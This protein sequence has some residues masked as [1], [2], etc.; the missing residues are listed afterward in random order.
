M[1]TRIVI[2]GIG[3]STSLGEGVSANW[4]ALTQGQRSFVHNSSSNGFL[5]AKQLAESAT[6]EALSKSNL[7]NFQGQ[8]PEVLLNRVWGLSLEVDP[9]RLGSTVS[10]SKPLFDGDSPQPPELLNE[11][12]RERFGFSGEARNVIAACATG[13]YSV[14]MAASWIEQGVC[15]VAL[16]GSVEPSPHPLIQAG[17]H[18]M[19]VTSIDGQTRPFDRH[20]SGFTFG[21]GAGILVLETEARARARGVTPY[22][23]LSGRALGADGHSAFTFNSQG[24]KIS[25]VIDQSLRSANLDARDILHVNAH[26]TATRHNDWI[27]TQALLKSFGD[28]AANLMISATKAST[29]H[30]LGASGAV[31]L[32]F[33]VLALRHQFVP[34]TATLET[35][36]PE[37]PLDYTPRVGHAATFDHAVSLSFGFGG[38]IGSIVVSRV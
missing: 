24:G 15:D 17:F 26:G 19:G 35:P 22:A 28:H 38:P 18:Q 2:T 33:T 37:C 34:P 1:K 14:A 16:A 4:E 7:I 12:L 21:S 11:Y 9:E 29:G 23:I 32:I 8:S 31:E 3:L 20:R 10:A 25:S 5:H 30:L 6:L 13:I 36:D 27:E